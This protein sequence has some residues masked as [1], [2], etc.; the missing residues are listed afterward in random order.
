MQIMELTAKAAWHGFTHATWQGRHYTLAQINEIL[1]GHDIG[2]CSCSWMGWHADVRD[3]A[4]QR[5]ERPTPDEEARAGGIG[6]VRTRTSRGDDG[7]WTTA[8]TLVPQ[9]QFLLELHP[10]A[11]E[12]T[13]A[14]L[15][16]E[17]EALGDEPLDRE[18]YERLCS[19]FGLEPADNEHIRSKPSFGRGSDY[20]ADPTGKVRVNARLH[21]RRRAA[22]R[23]VYPAARPVPVV[24]LDD[25]RSG[26]TAGGDIVADMLGLPTPTDATLRG[27]CHYCGILLVNGACEECDR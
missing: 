17:V 18:E 19:Q 27:E 7:E 25:P 16:A 3:M 8:Y 6:T 23:P 10:T 13:A 22:L 9:V 24:L 2:T 14:R 1:A 5:S 12:E 4:S 21:D 20:S 26:L 15:I 11:D